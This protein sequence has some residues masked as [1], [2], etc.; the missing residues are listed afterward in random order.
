[1]KTQRLSIAEIQIYFDASG[2]ARFSAGQKRRAAVELDLNEYREFIDRW[3]EASEEAR[4][5]VLTQEE[6]QIRSALK[7]AAKGLQRHHD[8][9]FIEICLCAAAQRRREAASLTAAQLEEAIADAIF[10]L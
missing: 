6:R 10:S 9:N 4:P 3:L 2:V 1:M 8:K 7:G 5:P